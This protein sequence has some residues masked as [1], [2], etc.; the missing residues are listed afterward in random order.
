VR[1]VIYAMQFKGQAGPVDGR[2][3]VL[4]AETSG[5]SCAL[6]SVVGPGGLSGLLQSAAGGSARF[7]SEVTFSGGSSFQESGSITFGRGEHRLRFSTV[8]E[9][10]LGTS[11]DGEAR[12]GAVTW[13]VDSG[14]GQ[15]AGASGLI[16]SNFLV[17]AGGEVTDNHFG[18][19]WV[20]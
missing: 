5:P 18:L 17:G 7:E 11:P 20:E 12:H 4:R 6:T 13:R 10:Y 3:G 2:P 14:E 19:L 8:G 1:Q 15:F 9:G 16:T